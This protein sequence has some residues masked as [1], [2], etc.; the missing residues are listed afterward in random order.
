MYALYL[1]TI[2]LQSAYQDRGRALH[3]SWRQTLFQINITS[4][5]WTTNGL[6]RFARPDTSSLSLSHRVPDQ[7]TR[8]GYIYHARRGLAGSTNIPPTIE[9]VSPHNTWY[10]ILST[11]ISTGNTNARRTHSYTTQRWEIIVRVSN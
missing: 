4:A 6:S 2:E 1:H 7:I 8:A 11:S 5:K 10:R 9:H 3:Q